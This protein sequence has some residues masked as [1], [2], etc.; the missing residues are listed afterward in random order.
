M[1]YVWSA[2]TVELSVWKRER[3][4]DGQG[5]KKEGVK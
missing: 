4:L 2:E 1:M 5:R 3:I